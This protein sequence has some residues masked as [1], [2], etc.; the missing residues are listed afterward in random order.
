MGII[1]VCS[2]SFYLPSIK[3]NKAAGNTL[4]LVSL[5]ACLFKELSVLRC[6]EY[7]IHNALQM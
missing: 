4:P 3:G 6:G 7:K 1:K 5:N 2:H